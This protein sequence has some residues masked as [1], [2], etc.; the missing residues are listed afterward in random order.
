MLVMCGN[1]HQGKRFQY[2]GRMATVIFISDR[3]AEGYGF[4]I[5]TDFFR[6]Y[7]DY[8]DYVVNLVRL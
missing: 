8:L 1:G 4:N 6:E 3:R 2:D 7:S 5:T